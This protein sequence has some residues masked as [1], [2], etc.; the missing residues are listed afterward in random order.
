MTSYTPEARA[1]AALL[2]ERGVGRHALFLTSREG[3]PLP[4][5]LES[6]SGF[7]LDVHGRVHA[8]WLTWDAEADAL[9]LAPFYAVEQP[10][11]A[12]ADDEEYHAARRVLGLR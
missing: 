7:A 10:A 5:G 9:T 12:F 6:V 1:I 3:T 11:E 2:R 4:D 8:F